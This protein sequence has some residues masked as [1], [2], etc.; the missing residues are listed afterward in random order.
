MKYRKCT[1][2][3]EFYN[4]YDDQIEQYD[5]VSGAD[6]DNN[7]DVTSDCRDYLSNA[8]SFT[9]FSLLSLL[10]NNSISGIVQTDADCSI[11]VIIIYM[12][13]HLL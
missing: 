3:E 6:T 1:R 10:V 8:T 12:Y 13:H 2:F 7:D 4:L 11:P 5:R 9:L